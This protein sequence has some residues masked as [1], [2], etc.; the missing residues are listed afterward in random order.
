MSGLFLAGQI[1]GT[2]GYEEAAAQGLIAGHQRGAARAERERR[3]CSDRSTSYIGIAGGRPTYARVPGAVPDVHLPRRASPAAADRQRRPAADARWPGKS[4]WWTTSGGSG[5]SAG[6]IG[7]IGTAP[8]FGRPIVRDAGR[9]A[10][11]GGAGA[12]A[13][14]VGLAHLAG[15]G[16]SV[17][18]GRSGT[19][20]RST[21]PASKSE[22]KY[23]GYLRRQDAPRSSGI[24]DRRH[25]G[26][27]G[28]SLIAGS[29]PLPRDGAAPVVGP[30][31]NARAGLR[32]SRV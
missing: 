7:S 5:S 30:A 11:S 17:A 20:P 3:S 2:S 1:N 14:G 16:R 19:R 4:G 27:R 21:S 6:A 32:T 29:R 28:T 8:R 25:A 15:G 31:R 22:F 12:E 18:R 10:R 24:G 9:V 23:E 26:S 13:A